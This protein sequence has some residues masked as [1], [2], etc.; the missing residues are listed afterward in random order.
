LI[1]TL[2]GSVNV[3]VDDVIVDAFIGSENTILGE[4]AS[5]KPV[6]DGDGETEY[7][8]GA[9]VSADPEESS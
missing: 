2:D 5:G 3:T 1:T 4:S 8:F 7:T 9:A 6:D